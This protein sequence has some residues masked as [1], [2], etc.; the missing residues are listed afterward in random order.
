MVVHI[1]AG[2]QYVEALGGALGL[3][4]IQK[5]WQRDTT[6]SGAKIVASTWR[7]ALYSAPFQIIDC[8]IIIP[9]PVIPD[10][11]GANDAA[12][13]IIQVLYEW[14]VQQMIDCITAEVDR[15]ECVDSIMVLLGPYY[16][17]ESVRVALRNVFDGVEA[18]AAAA[19]AAYATD[20]PYQG[21]YNDLR[22]EILNNEHW[23]DQLSD[24]LF[25]H[26][27]GLS[28]AILAGLDAVAAALT[29]QGVISWV[30]AHGGI[31]DGAGAGFGETDVCAWV[32]T[33]NF[34]E[35]PGDF[36]PAQWPNTEPMAEWVDGL[37]WRSTTYIED[38]NP[39]IQTTALY[40]VW[41]HPPFKWNR[42][43]AVYTLDQGSVENIPGNNR[44]FYVYMANL[45]Y[46]MATITEGT[47]V[48]YDSTFGNTFTGLTPMTMRCYTG[49]GYEGQ[50][51]HGL[52]I[53]HEMT[54][55]GVGYNPFATGG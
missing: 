1:P 55:Y 46:Y 52:A 6:R 28:D 3:L 30:N 22:D 41:T 27:Q 13:T 9:P 15:D 39:D 48:I 20:C 35:T 32:H 33:I 7:K 34:R 38:F 45:A 24:W 37:G 51:E 17:G 29:G 8:P 18:L 21:L 47:E 10:E 4:T 54:I 53:L 31:V 23:L 2:V 5:S 42:F 26:L 40:N 50:S 12:A 14:I 16:A 36:I 43:T 19:R 44:I 11:D 25:D 49:Q